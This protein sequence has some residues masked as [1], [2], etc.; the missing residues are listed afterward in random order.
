LVCCA[1]RSFRPRVGAAYGAMSYVS[2]TIFVDRIS[3]RIAV[4]V[5]ANVVFDLDVRPST[6][7]RLEYWLD[8]NQVWLMRSD[9]LMYVVRRHLISFD[10]ALRTS[11]TLTVEE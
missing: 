9:G 11:R 2:W 4:G 1:L 7:F 3:M 6:R 8:T 10:I 5:V